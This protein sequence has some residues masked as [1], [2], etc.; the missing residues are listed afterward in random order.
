MTFFDRNGCDQPAAR[1]MR[2]AAIS[3]F[4]RRSPAAATPQSAVVLLVSADAALPERIEHALA[5]IVSRGARLSCCSDAAIAATVSPK[6]HLSLM[7]VDLCTARTAGIDLIGHSRAQTP[8]LPIL[9]IADGA[10]EDDTFAAAMHAGASGYLLKQRDDIEIALS[11]RS[12]LHGGVPIDPFVAGNLLRGAA[13]AR[14]AQSANTGTACGER[15]FGQL[16]ERERGVLV[17]LASGMSNGKIAE[18]IR[19]S[20][21]TVETH[22]KRLYS[23]L[24]AHTRMEAVH[25]ARSFGLI[26]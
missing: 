17:L 13:P 5:I 24:E 26:A 25:R 7:L 10:D 21:N 22:I 20:R 11:L 9:A 18:S 14:I 8:R 6:T 4:Q 23:K 16:T 2:P 19:L 15:A 1:A 12:A 3:A